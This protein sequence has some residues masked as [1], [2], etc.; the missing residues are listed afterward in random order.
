MQEMTITVSRRSGGASFVARR[1][2]AFTLVELLVV[3]AIIGILIALLLPA[4]QAAREA[5]RRSQCKNSLKQ[6]GLATLMHEDSLGVLPTGGWVYTRDRT[7]DT[8]G[9]PLSLD[10][11]AW[12]WRYQIMRYI[13]DGALW[14]E[15]NEDVVRRGQPPFVNCPSRR[16]P[17]RLFD[18]LAVDAEEIVVGDYVGNGGDT[19]ECGRRNQGLTP[20]VT[21]SF[22]F[23]TGAFTSH[24]PGGGICTPALKASLIRL[25]MFEDGTSKTMLYGE[26]YVNATRT[27][28]GT[29]GDNAGWYAGWS[30]DS[31][32][33]AANVPQPDSY[34]ADD[35][36][37]DCSPEGNDFFGAAHPGGFNICRVDGSVDFT[38][39]DIEHVALKQLCNRRDAGAT[40]QATSGPE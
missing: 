11:Q 14:A 38:S 9:R 17:T 12:G 37:T 6:L 5:A 28:G 22:N 13:E 27:D 39:F 19:D 3:I 36:N 21:S 33:F 15:E 31:I 16:Q 4:V 23:H 34:R 8:S 2:G 25:V 10:H 1:V 7:V 20:D 18:R 32:R 30:W 29:C 24:I 35:A 26:K 40:R